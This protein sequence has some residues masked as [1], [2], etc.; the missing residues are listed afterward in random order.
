MNFTLPPNNRV[1]RLIDANLDRAREGLRVIE[2]WC[3][4]GL[5]QKDLVIKIKDFRHQLSLLHNEKFKKARSSATDKGALLNHPAQKERK[6][7]NELISANCSR[8]QE[9]LRVLEEFGRNTSPELAKTAASIRYEIYDLEIKI[10]ALNNLS[11]KKLILNNT[12]VYLITASKVDLLSKLKIAIQ[13]GIKMV[14]Y[15][16]KNDNKSDFE[17]IQEANN[18]ASICKKYDCL[19]IVNDRIDIAQAVDA[20][21]VHLGQND[22]PIEIARNLVGYEKI[23]GKSTSNFEQAKK[24]EAQGADYIGIGPVFNSNNKSNN[25]L[26]EKDILV[27]VGKEI[28]I[29]CFAI[30][31]INDS[32]KNIIISTGIDRI[33][34]IDGILNQNDIELSTKNLLKGIQ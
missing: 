18:I 25:N 22:M 34:L 13:S 23:I 26:I 12:H 6:N 4:F 10:L 19:F 8:I 3:R 9:A 28:Q 20:D 1:N 32:N 17:K 29:P 31:G 15:R 5:C 11:N 14:Q 27:N 16:S 33:A 21:G 2:D 30:G 7:I 24:A